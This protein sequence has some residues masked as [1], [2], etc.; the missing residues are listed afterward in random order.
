MDVY[1]QVKII[2]SKFS[3]DNIIKLSVVGLQN[4][5]LWGIFLFTYWIIF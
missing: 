2:F 5:D 1:Q 3:D 4:H